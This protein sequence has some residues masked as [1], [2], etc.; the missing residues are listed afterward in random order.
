MDFSFRQATLDDLDSSWKILEDAIRRRKDDGSDQWQDGYPNLSV[1][2]EDINKKIAYVLTCSND[3]V[4]YCTILINDEPAYA[5]IEGKWLSDGDYVV[6]HR[7]AISENYL[8]KGL[9][10]KILKFIE[11]YALSNH[12]YSIKADTNFDN[13]GMLKTFEK[14]DYKYCGEVFLRGAPRKAYEKLLSRS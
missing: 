9:A 7:L 2:T 1:I 5:N 13:I 14:L 10:K 8:G 4:G 6:C 11:E 3:I 12:I